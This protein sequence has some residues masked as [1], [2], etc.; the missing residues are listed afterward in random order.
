MVFVLFFV[1]F[2]FLVWF[3][4]LPLAHS[5]YTQKVSKTLTNTYSAFKQAGPKSKSLLVCLA[6]CQVFFFPP[7]HEKQLILSLI[8]TPKAFNTS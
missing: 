7:P 3:Y 5:V 6:L 4:S 1:C 8:Q 2:C